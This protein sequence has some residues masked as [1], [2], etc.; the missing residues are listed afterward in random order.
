MN[1]LLAFKAEPDLSMLAEK[2]WLAAG[3]TAWTLR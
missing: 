3:M 1:I 2:D